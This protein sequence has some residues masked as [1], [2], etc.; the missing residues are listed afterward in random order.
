MSG[1]NIGDGLVT[2]LTDASPFDAGNVSKDD[3]GIM[4]TT[5]ACALIVMPGRLSAGEHTQADGWHLTW[6]IELRAYARDLGDTVQS[7]RNVWTL[8]DEIVA[9]VR[10]DTSLD[11]SACRSIVSSINRPFDT[12]VEIFGQTWFPLT[13]TVQAD[14]YLGTADGQVTGIDVYLSLEN[15]SGT[16]FNVSQDI[17]TVRL[18]RDIT[19]AE[20]TR[21]GTEALRV[22]DGPADWRLDGTAFY[23]TSTSGMDTVINGLIGEQTVFIFG[24]SGSTSGNVQ[25]TGSGIMREYRIETP[26]GEPVTMAFQILAS[27]GSMTRGSF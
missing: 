24:P 11:S 2:T 3:F 22:T 18:T 7:M 27:A 16:K 9:A 26:L 6:D 19:A 21:L 8:A 15:S 12:T 25:Y 4:E 20:T 5:N 14:E 23:N 10:A 17:Q 1:S 13:C